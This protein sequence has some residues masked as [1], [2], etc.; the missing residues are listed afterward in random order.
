VKV[1][2]RYVP[3]LINLGVFHIDTG[4]LAA[5]EQCLLQALKLQ[6][7]SQQARRFLSRVRAMG[8]QK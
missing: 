6:P 8:G 4:N 1:N 2:S 7:S 5:A 3:G